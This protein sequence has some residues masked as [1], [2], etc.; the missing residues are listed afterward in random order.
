[1][2][3]WSQF[4]QESLSWVPAA[5]PVC[6]R[7]NRVELGC[8]ELEISQHY[9]VT[10]IASWKPERILILTPTVQNGLFHQVTVAMANSFLLL[11]YKFTLKERTN[12]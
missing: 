10:N 6:Y 4:S 9:G 2:V 12:I 5:S 3:R 1:M 8:R 11:G 7:V